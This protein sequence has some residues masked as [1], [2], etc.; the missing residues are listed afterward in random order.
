MVLFERADALIEQADR[1]EEQGELPFI[2]VDAAERAVETAILQ[3]PLWLVSPLI[4]REWL[5]RRAAE[6]LALL[7]VPLG[8]LLGSFPSGY[9]PAVGALASTS[10]NWARAQRAPP[11]C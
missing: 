1:L 5:T 3:F 10:A 4:P 8:Y 2:V 7:V 11:M 9:L 6:P